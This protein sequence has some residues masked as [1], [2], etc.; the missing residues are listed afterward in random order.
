MLSWIIKK[1]LDAFERKYGYDVSYARELLAV[2]PRALM[3]FARTEGM[4]KYRRDVPA[5]VYYAV[6]LTGIIHEDCGPCTQLGVAMALEAGVTDK[7]LASIV[8][9]DVTTM[10][11]EVALGVKFARASL[12]HDLEAD[13]YREEIEKRW[14][15]RAV[16][17]L[18]FALTMS[19]VY[20]TLKYAL[21]FGKACSRVV[22]GGEHIVVREA[23]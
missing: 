5:H 12:A 7:V 23:A 10:S 13:V 1:R 2:D 16:V 18:A 9:G 20:P 14:G 3:A 4:G 21:G 11:D 19:R 22:V 15:K 6:K 17:S 8:R